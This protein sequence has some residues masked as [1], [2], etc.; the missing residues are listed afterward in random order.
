MGQVIEGEVEH[1][2]RLGR[3]LGFPTANL[4]VPEDLEIPDGV[5]RSRVEIEGRSY[6]AMSNLGRNP[7]VGGV[8]RRLETH[9]FG[10]RGE[11]YGR[12]LRVE[13][14]ERIR[15]ERTFASTEELRAQILRD[16]TRILEL[17]RLA[18]ERA[19]AEELA[20]ETPSRTPISTSNPTG[21]S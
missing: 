6:A 2:R 8:A 7:S 21:K 4:P 3:R 20:R 11:L 1:G 14:L 19:C 12:R 5:Y 15:G 17:E 10:F 16:R 9:L 13:L 18:E